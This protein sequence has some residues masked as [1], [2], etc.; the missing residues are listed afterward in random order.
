MAVPKPRKYSIERNYR[1]V[2][3][4]LRKSRTRAGLTQRQVAD[5]LGYSSSQFISNFEAGISVPPLRKLVMLEQ[6]YRIDLHELMEIVF[7]L[8]RTMEF[9]QKLKQKKSR[10]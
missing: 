5:T 2:G 1:P 9:A 10:S 7:Q 6:L 8:E 3:D 4:Y